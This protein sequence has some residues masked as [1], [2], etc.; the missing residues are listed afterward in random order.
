VGSNREGG[1]VEDDMQPAPTGDDLG[2]D[3]TVPASAD[4]PDG[5]AEP[6]TPEDEAGRLDD[7]L[8]AAIARVRSLVVADVERT[9]RRNP[10]LSQDQLARL[11]VKRGTRRVGATSFA[12]GFGGAPSLALNIPS[13][14]TLQASLVL[15]VAAVYDELDSPDL[16]QDMVLILAGNSAVTALR[17]FGVAAANDMGKRWVQRNVTRETM[18]QVNKVV[19]RKIL[20]KAGEKSLT[21]FVRLVPVA[22]AAVG[23]T[24]DRSY[25][26]ALGQSAIR[27]YSGR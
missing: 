17:S 12:T 25:A 10:H 15:G 13:V 27:Y 8:V 3:A 22:G 14:L 2:T 23:Y 5:L 21:S 18:K 6:E 19:S 7:L 11:V 4:S 24:V 26:R 16:R 20:T 1:T 9:R